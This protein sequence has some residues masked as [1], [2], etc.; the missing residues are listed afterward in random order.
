MHAC[1]KQKP[2]Q[3]PG[4]VVVEMKQKKH[5]QFKREGNDLHITMEITLKDALLGFSTVVDHLDDHEV[6][7]TEKGVVS[8]GQVRK[9]K[10]E[11]MPVHN[12]P[13]DLGDLYVTYKV[14][15]PKKISD[16]ARALLEQ[17]AALGAL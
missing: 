17:A 4:D 11:G 1:T 8:P 10:G 13:S 2:G 15:M 16:E 6:V 7:V 9:I 14:K 3:I 12:F 5:P